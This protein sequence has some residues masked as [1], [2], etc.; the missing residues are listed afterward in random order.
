[1]D[2]FDYVI[3][4]AGSAGCVLARR[5]SDDPRNRVL[6]VEAGGDNQSPFIRM[7]GGFMKI[8]GKPNYFWAFPVKERTGRRKE[9]QVY[10][11]GL[12]GSSAINGTWYLTGM[13]QD[14]DGWEKIGLPGWG[15]D[16]IA[17]CYR[18]LED[19]NYPGAADF[20]GRGG[21]LQITQSTY[22]SSVFRALVGACTAMGVPWVEDI[23]TP[24]A[25]GVGRTQYTVDRRG[26][27]ASSY[28]AFL[29][30]VRRRPNLTILTGCFL[31]GLAFEGNR[32]TGIKCRH[33]G[34]DRHFNARREVIL[35][36]GVHQSPAILQ[37]AGIGPAALLSG[38]GIPVRRNL[39]AVGRNLCDHMKLGI[40]CEL[41]SHPGVNRE[42]RGWRL[43]RNAMRYF[44]TGTGALARVGM[45]LTMLYSG[46]NGTPDWPEFQLAAA[47]FAMKTVNEMTENPGS[48]LSTRPGITFSGYHLRPKSRGNVEITTSDP[49]VAPTVD[50]RIWTEASDIAK[51]V[52]LL[53]LL[54]R[55][56]AAPEL[57]AFV[58]RERVPG[59]QHQ[60]DREL[61]EQ[62]SQLVEAG[63]HGTGTCSMGT[64]AATS[65]VDA[66]CR[67]HGFEKLRVVDCA[68][69]PTP[70]SGNT[71]GPAMAIAQRAA[72]LIL[73]DAA[74]AC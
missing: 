67:V 14:Y 8:M 11:K 4:G 52:E 55:I 23:C 64:D 7:P 41:H 16:E 72:E 60:S 20:R 32:A 70:V 6:L 74:G 34:C 54:R 43:Y 50:A 3:I 37:R 25:P 45:P 18:K 2:T 53:R 44:L 1:M 65:V 15:W 39:P 56:A 29:A 49:D 5:I 69:M 13:P 51:S 46:S 68:I 38:L 48:P 21:P 73:E 66:R 47:P 33:E 63:L 24:G 42:F 12:G 71:N 58:G 61:E 36:A 22:E 40:S 27:R 31:T 57:S 28:E 19:Y 10:G 30:P 35:S 26:R 62:L 9:M 59:E 17:R